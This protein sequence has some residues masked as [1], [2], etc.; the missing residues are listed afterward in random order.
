MVH[1]A[2]RPSRYLGAVLTCVHICASAIL[3]PLELGAEAK[4][5]LAVAIAVSLAHSVWRYALL[6]SRGAVVSIAL[7]DRASGSVQLKDGS[8]RSARIL[9]TTYVSPLLTVVN[10]RMAGHRTARHVVIVPDNIDPEDFR[11]LRVILKWAYPKQSA[12]AISA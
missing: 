9:G 5:I 6:K 2:L 1:A 11:K 4:L 12:K 8:W 3:L 7:S 10:V